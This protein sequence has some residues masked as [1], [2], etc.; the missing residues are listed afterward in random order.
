MGRRA[1]PDQ[2]KAVAGNPGKR[3]RTRPQP[4]SKPA[5]P[6]SIAVASRD[7]PPTWLTNVVAKRIWS[8]VWPSLTRMRFANETDAPAFGRYCQYFAEWIEATKALNKDGKTQNVGTVSGDTMVRLHPA[9]KVRELAERHMMAMED[10]YALNPQARFSLAQQLLDKP[11]L[12]APGDLFEHGEHAPST[13]AAP[14]ISD[15]PM[16]FLTQGHETKPH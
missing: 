5:A 4:S 9:V 3:K 8:N 2:I 1:K 16:A 7:K 13:P 14:V 6:A 10:R 12:G 15:D 11:G